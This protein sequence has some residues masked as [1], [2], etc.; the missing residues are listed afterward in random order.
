MVFL[1][2]FSE[3]LIEKQPKKKPKQKQQKPAAP[4]M[5]EPNHWTTQS[6]RKDKLERRLWEL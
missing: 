5:E 1:N 3:K 2:E 4:I 6:L